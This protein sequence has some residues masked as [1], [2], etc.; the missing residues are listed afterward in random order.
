MSAPVGGTITWRLRVLD[1]RNYGP[2]T[3]VYVDI[4]LPPG[5]QV[6]SA[7]ADR[8]P[9]CV[10][11][12]AGKLRCNLDWLSSDAPYANIVVV[13]NVT[14][15]GELVLTAVVGYSRAD[16][17]PSNNSLTLKANTPVP[18]V[19]SPPGGGRPQIGTAKDDTLRG[20]SRNDTLSGLGG[21]DLL[22]GLAGNDLLKGGAGNDK[23]NGG[24]GNDT[25]YGGSGN[26][27][28]TGGPGSDRVFGGPG[29]D[30]IYARD[31]VKDA[32]DCGGGRDTVFAD[33]K[34]GVARNCEVVRRR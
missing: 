29:N 2:A 9:G 28:I 34:D 10:S 7:T 6:V 5:V 19:P 11:S 32:I 23:L 24:A 33:K 15:A 20:T 12:G 16:S 8:G 26:D 30:T 4:T 13:T 27:V 18:V 21:N 25:L 22:N 1:D 31:R 3:G 17:D 14:A